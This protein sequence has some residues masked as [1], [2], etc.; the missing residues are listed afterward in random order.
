MTL[1][2]C[3]PSFRRRACFLVLALFLSIHPAPAEPTELGPAPALGGFAGYDVRYGLDPKADP[4]A[5]LASPVLTHASVQSFTHSPSGEARLEGL[6]ESQVIVDLPVSLLASVLEAQTGAEAWLP[7]T[8][9]SRVESRNG[10]EA[11][12]YEEAGSS[13]LGVKLAL[14]YTVSQV[15]DELLGGAMGFR[16]RVVESHDGKLF[17][18]CTSWYLLPIVVDGK[19]KTYV[20]YFSRSGLRKPFLGAETLLKSYMPIQMTGMVKAILKEA[21]RRQAGA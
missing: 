12:L 18:S 20:R 21:R 7:G 16:S 17:E 10:P 6:S 9:L 1:F 15:R 4:Q 2:P 19:A 11:R 5:L 14:R 3:L 8:I 13:F